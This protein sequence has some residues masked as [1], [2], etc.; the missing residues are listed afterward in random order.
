M[1]QGDLA[2]SPKKGLLTKTTF[3]F[4]DETGFSDRPTVRYTWAK[5]GHTPHIKS[6]GGWKHRSVLGTLL[7]RPDSNHPRFLF[8]VQKKGVRAKTFLKYLEKLKQHQ[9]GRHLT[10][11]LD[12]LPAHK[13]EIVQTWIENNRGWLTVHRFPSY[14]PEYN[15]AEYVWS[16]T[17]SKDH[18]NRCPKDMA[19]LER[20]IR[21]GLKR[22]SQ[23]SILKGCLKASRLY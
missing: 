20:R 22:V 1:V 23:T 10:L 15:P 16:A 13:A 21:K 3:A 8:T 9:R 4:H 12:G 17:K 6:T 14:A 2:G 11:F 5:R 7:C 18:G 19:A